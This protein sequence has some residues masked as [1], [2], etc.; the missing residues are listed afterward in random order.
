[1]NVNILFTNL[2]SIHGY[3]FQNF[4]SRGNN[5]FL[6]E[7]SF[8]FATNSSCTVIGFCRHFLTVFSPSHFSFSNAQMKVRILPARSRVA[9]GFS[10][11]MRCD[12]AKSP[13]APMTTSIIDL[14]KYY[15][16]KKSLF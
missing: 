16:H 7:L 10:T 1:M 12:V 11:I 13:C 3:Y 9:R 2:L 4:F 5:A 14:P 15:L 6:S 8:S